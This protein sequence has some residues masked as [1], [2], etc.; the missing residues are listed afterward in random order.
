MK[1]PSLK[2]KIYGLL[3]VYLLGRFGQ[4]LLPL[5]ESNIFAN[6]RKVTLNLVAL[7]VDKNLYN[8]SLKNS[9]DRYTSNYIQ[10]KISNSRAIV[11]PIDTTAIKARD[12]TKMLEN[13]YYD[14][15]EK[16]PSSLKGVILI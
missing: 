13:I 9:I 5:L 15:V 4:S 8:G 12:I 6:E 7:I 16:E 11:F 10:Q 1:Q 3:I 14:G 2:L